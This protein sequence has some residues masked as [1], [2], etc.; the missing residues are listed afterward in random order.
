M[1][2]VEAR[3]VKLEVHVSL[4]EISAAVESGQVA[5]QRE[6]AGGLDLVAEARLGRAAPAHEQVAHALD[7][8]TSNQHRRRFDKGFGPAGGR[9]DIVRDA[10]AHGRDVT[11]ERDRTRR[12]ERV[13]RRQLG[14]AK[15]E[16]RRRERERDQGRTQHER[17]RC[18]GHGGAD[19][20]HADRRLR[21][22]QHDRCGDHH[23]P[24][25]GHDQPRV[26]RHS[27]RYR[28]AMT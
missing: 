3:G 9:A 28:R 23:R 15:P 13:G 22:D 24:R 18:D 20:E 19:R 21:G 17:K 2:H 7:L 5:W 25:E 27:V 8:G 6:L 4:G 10:P 14:P 16:Q 12:D 11:R 1:D 26:A